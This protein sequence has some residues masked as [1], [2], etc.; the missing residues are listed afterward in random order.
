MQSSP[1][2]STFQCAVPISKHE[3][4]FPAQDRCGAEVTRL[5]FPLT[6]S[7]VITIHKVQGLT[8]DMIVVDMKEVVLVQDK[9]M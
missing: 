4:K 5:Q 7:W 2:R 3:A 8:L 6:L 9:H 1:Y